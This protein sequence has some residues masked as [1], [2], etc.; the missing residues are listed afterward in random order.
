MAVAGDCVVVLITAPTREVA[1]ELGEGL[2]REGLAACVNIIPAVTS[3]FN[4]EEK[5]CREEE[6]LMLVKSTAEIFPSVAEHVRRHHPYE[7][8]EVVALPVADGLEAYL[9]WVRKSCAGPAPIPPS[10]G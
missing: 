4:W 9:D 10:A 6:V 2:V 1:E 5:L 8:P 3:I 7:L